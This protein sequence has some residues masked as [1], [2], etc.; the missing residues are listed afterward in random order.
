MNKPKFD[1]KSFLANNILM[2]SLLGLVIVMIIVE[3]RF[4]QTRVLID[5]LSQSSTRMIIAL[6]ILFTLLV[7]GT[8][9]SAGRIV[10][11]SG[12]IAASML[13]NLDYSNRF[14]P[15]LPELPLIVPILIAVFVCMLFGL[16][17]GILVAKLSLQPFIAT[18]AV[19]VI[20][21]GLASV[22]FALPPNN[23]QPI[24][25]LRSDFTALGQLR[26]P[27]PGLPDGLP[28][29]ILYAAIFI[30]FVWFLLNKTVFGKNIYAIGGNRAAAQVSGV[31]VVRTLTLIFIIASAFYAF[32]GILESARTAGST[33]NYGLGYELDAIAACVVGGVSLSGGIGKVRGVV[34]GVLIFTVIN[35][36]LT[37]MGINPYWQQI[38]KGIIIIAAVAMDVRKYKSKS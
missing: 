22:Y 15:N 10:G 4:L 32:G 7:G 19:Q 36:G 31:N 27:F 26:I 12:L 18:L 9:L 8:D 25:G 2:I 21:Y 13:Q 17:N 5:I 33:S 1:L 30:I 16:L 34:L 14:F 24:G 37:F 20:V 11:F 38:I 28:V 35:Y 3:P 29:L 6:G 23:A